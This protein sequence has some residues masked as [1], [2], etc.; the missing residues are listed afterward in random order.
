M[1][2]IKPSVSGKGAT[3]S[4]YDG[5]PPTPGTY[6]GKIKKMGLARIQN[7]DNAGA[8]RIALLIEITQ[9]K[10]KG[11]GVMHSLNLTEQGAPYVNQFLH[12]MTD[13]SD[14]QKEMI[15]DWF[16]E[17][18]FDTQ[19]DP[20]GKMGR[21]FNFIGKPSF[22]PIGKNVAFVTKMDSY[23]GAEKAA[24]V[25]FVVPLEGSGSEEPETE[26]EEVLDESPTETV[27]SDEDDADDPWE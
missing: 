22:K 15:E 9:G 2:R 16:W 20:D 24:I 13:G 26:V 3:V 7:G 19:E 5:P 6:Q 21:Q 25:S 10:F 11:A 17:K 4:Y 8:D 27:V 18:G 14:Q 12:A 23:N 1:V